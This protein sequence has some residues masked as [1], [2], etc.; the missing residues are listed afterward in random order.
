MADT[1]TLDTCRFERSAG[2]EPTASFVHE[3][4]TVSFSGDLSA[5]EREWCSFQAGA[6]CTVFQSFEWLSA[7]QRHIGARQGVTPLIVSLRDSERRP[8]A[9]L[10][11][12]LQPVG[13]V[14]ELVWLGMELCDYTGPLLAPDFSARVSRETFR[15]MWRRI[16]QHAAASASFDVVRLEKMPEA[17]GRQ[18]NPMLQFD[19]ARNPSGAYWTPLSPSWDEFYAAK[20]SASTRRRDR[21]KRKN[22]ANFGEVTFVQPG[23]A[24]DRLATID[25]LMQQKARSLARIGVANF[26]ET[27]GYA[28]FYRAVSGEAVAHVSRLD[29]GPHR[30]AINLGLMMHSRYY[31]VLASY[32]DEPDVLRY[33]P[34]AAHLMDIM[35]HAIERG[36]TVFDFTIGDE[37]YKRDWCDERQTLYDH[38]SART[39]K[40]AAAVLSRSLATRAKRTIKENPALWDAF[41]KL[42]SFAGTAKQR[43]SHPD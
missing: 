27:P 32:T 40:G 24:A 30:A 42:R 10:P 29:V 41:F 15:A 12:A 16:L 22:L 31:H 9:L 21:T 6:D 36:C 4:L 39:L 43:L 2:A 14:R 25:L 11:L 18:A 13:F 1:A 33:G 8:L 26:F 20:R 23:D 38:L 17:I 3:G 35:A 19:V 7:W 37:P 34:G 28:E 5:V